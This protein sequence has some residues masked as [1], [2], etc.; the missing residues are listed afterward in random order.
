M[1]FEDLKPEWQVFVTEYLKDFNAT[2]SY[3]VAYPNCTRETALSNGSRLLGNAK[4]KEYLS[5]QEK[6]RH[7]E[8]IMSREELLRY[9]TRVVRD[10]ETEE[11]LMSKALGKGVTDIVSKNKRV[12][13][14]DRNKAAELLA[15]SYGMLTD[16]VENKTTATIKVDDSWFEE[17]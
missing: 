16:K 14:R 13:A 10:E 2:R 15:K 11:V 6:K 5:E 3:M 7:D 17:D 4:V 9:L 12:T 8:S 1:K